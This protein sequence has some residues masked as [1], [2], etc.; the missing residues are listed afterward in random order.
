MKIDIEDDN[1]L[2]V[3]LNRVVS[4]NFNFTEKDNLEDNFRSIFNSIKDRYLLDIS[5]YYNIIMYKDNIYGIILEVEKDPLEYFDYFNQIEM[6]ITLSN[7]DVFLYKII[8]NNLNFDIDNIE[9]YS[10]KGNL[11]AK[12]KETISLIELGKLLEYSNIIYGEK[13]NIVLKYGNVIKRGE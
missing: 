10:Y 6:R 8:D 13:T 2:I 7:H 4:D 5:G 12:A 1:N 9:L 11:Y 3:F